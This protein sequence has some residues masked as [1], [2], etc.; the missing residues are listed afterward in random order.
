MKPPAS[1]SFGASGRTTAPLWSVLAPTLIAALCVCASALA[2]T[3]PPQDDTT[4]PPA[5][6]PD[7]AAPPARPASDK[8]T[9]DGG[10]KPDARLDKVYVE[11]MSD[12]AARRASTAAKIIV[13]REE[14][15]RYGDTTI[16]ETLKRLPGI[17]TGGRPGRGGDIR[18]RGMGNGYTQVLVNGERMPPGFSIDQIPPDQVERIEILRAPTAEYGARAVAGTINIVLREALQ[19]RMNEW[20]LIESQEHGSRRPSAS[21]TR[22]DKL[23]DHGGAY[24]LTVNAMRNEHNDDVASTAVT[25]VLATGQ[26]GVVTNEGHNDA[27]SSGL[28]VTGRVQL[29]PTKDDSLSFQP[30]V[31]L[32]AGSSANVYDQSQTLCSDD[33]AS[34][35]HCLGFDHAT[36]ATRQ[37]SAM[38]R[39]MGQW[40]H[41]FD[42]DSKLE[43][44]LG[45]GW[46]GSHSHAFREEFL[47]D[48][49]SRTQDDTI[50]STHDSWNFTG[51]YS[52][53]L[54]DDHDLVAGVEAEGQ[55]LDQT[56]V[57]L[58]DGLP[59][60][61][62]AS[63]G[64]NVDATA[65]R[66]AL[67]A[68]DEWTVG[69]QW[70]F[71]AGL[72]GEGITT[73]SAASSYDV[74]NRSMVWTP[75]L[76][77]LWKF[78]P[79]S[80]D[81]LRASLTRS[82]RSPPLQSLVALPGIN[83]LY[84]C[85]DTGLCGANV[86]NAPDQTGNPAL[87]PEIARGVELAY[88]DYPSLGG[89]L[90]A[91]LFY[92]HIDNLI[93]TVTTLEN[94]AWA[95]V[96]RWVAQPQNI[97]VA[98]TAGVELEAKFRLDQ[99]W[100]DAPPIDLRSNLSLFH[101]RVDGIKGPHATLDNQPRGV[102]NL[103]FDY[104][105]RSLPLS[106]GGNVNYTPAQTIQQTD[107]QIAT[108]S[109]KRVY[110]A[111][112]LWT[113]NPAVA[114]RVSANNLAPLDYATGSI[115]TTPQAVVTSNAG[116]RSF[117]TWTLRLEIKS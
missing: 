25:N 83:P 88:E 104:R 28:H 42:E 34:E 5:K 110:D 75:L 69:K 67:Y 70:A 57:T 14:I 37:H 74:D 65:L 79:K 10:S 108:N 12:D 97:G 106:F 114:L 43:L 84:P 23:D 31:A 63:F 39:L 40:Q 30:F 73:R 50:A 18:M 17:T 90:S 59:R 61:Q 16:G 15:E 2:D 101:S 117:T 111:Y 33:P 82:Y 93:R 62:L 26:N 78:D 72:R 48:A 76:H 85:P 81:Q 19:K 113:F 115:I 107:I 109:K 100:D 9:D 29:K 112:G 8:S 46:M 45:G 47:D 103:G 27:A 6:T 102:G 7:K 77:A 21:W 68:Q 3:T 89:V 58:Q 22:N 87:K 86:V 54:G 91:N 35:I 99:Y 52:H 92:R 53:R 95:S 80:R 96:P 51:K 56:H 11:R 4:L 60:P 66:T 64:D 71:Y 94:V 24:N 32:N 20:R 55:R 49:L 44:H 1:R 105:L 116:G 36:T 98:T 38:A 41:R 13:G